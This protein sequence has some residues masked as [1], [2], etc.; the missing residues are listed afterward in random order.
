MNERELLA[1]RANLVEQARAMVTTCEAEKRDFTAEEQRSYD[2][3]FVDVEKLDK[4]IENQRKLAT[5]GS[6]E[7]VSG[8][9]KP[10]TTSM[11]TDKEKK[12][13][14][15]FRRTCDPG[16]CSLS[17]VRCRQIQM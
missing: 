9:I 2:E 5:A 17:F 13:A 8:A 16:Q 12:A 1:K 4:K 15:A 3:I 6:V 10:E 11:E 7:M 14:V